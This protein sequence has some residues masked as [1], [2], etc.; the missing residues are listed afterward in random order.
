M[1]VSSHAGLTALSIILTYKQLTEQNEEINLSESV[2][3]V[4]GAQIPYRLKTHT[5]SL[6]APG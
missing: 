5:N 2:S 6:P 3:G 1:C 4:N